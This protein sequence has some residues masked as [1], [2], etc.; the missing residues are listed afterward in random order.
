MDNKQRY[1]AGMKVRRAVLGATWVDKATAARTTFTEEWQ[2]HITQFAWGEIWTRP[3]LD[4]QK[5]SC[6]TLA[7]MI[8]LGR[9]EEFNLH[10]E[11]AFNNGLTEDDI[12]E[13]IMHAACYCGVPAG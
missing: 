7:L 5:R 11:A 1:A 12:K 2:A 9:W 13:V 8:A 10:V 6:M 4:R 3:G